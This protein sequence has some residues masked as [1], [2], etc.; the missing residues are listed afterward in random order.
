MDLLNK[1][2]YPKRLFLWL[3]GYSGLL[4]GCFIIFQYNREKEFKAMEMNS[5][6]QQINTF[7]LAELNKGVRPDLIAIDDFNAFDNLRISVIAKD[8]RVMFDNTVDSLPH[9]SH[10][11][12]AE[13]AQA[14]TDGEGYVVRRHS[15]S[16]GDTYFYSA[17]SDNSNYIVRT[18]IPYSI[19]LNA[20][21]KADYGFIWIMG[22][23]SVTM[24][25]LGYFATRRVGTHISRLNKFAE[26]V[27]KGVPISD[28]QPFPK[29]E[30]GSISNHLVRLYARLQQAN[31][32][33]DR[34]HR[35]ALREQEEKQRIKKELT[36]NINHELKTPVA[37]IQ[38]CIET[39]LAH[40]N[41]TSEKKRIFLQRIM[42]NAERLRRLLGDVSLLTRMDDGA[43]SISKRP[44]N[45]MSVIAESVAEREPIAAAKGLKIENEIVKSINME[46]DNL[47][48]AS[49]FNNLIDNA[50]SYSGGSKIWLK[51]L[52]E[53]HDKIE[54]EFSDNGTGVAEEHIPRLFERFYRIDKGR[55]R[56]TGGTGL[57]LSIVKKAVL[58]HGGSITAENR[59]EGGLLFRII[60]SKE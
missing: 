58:F 29:D 21:L 49:I 50:I 38:V 59:T 41:L 35:A 4:V 17:K 36:N 31:A 57:G 8:G 47:L 42:M 20:L 13:I 5:K 39:L 54:L 52:S 11:N 56:V 28:T 24:C 22:A 15:E 32:D 1:L 7:I 2:S 48:L 60:L 12:R 55:S 19:S 14:L 33:R 18:A 30:F 16:T 25:I 43:T 37:T 27:E 23:I 45:M 3:L 46:G 34:E 10:V 6:L 9:G 44:V 26:N 53:T 40:N 51:V